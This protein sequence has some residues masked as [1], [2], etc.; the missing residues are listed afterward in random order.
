[1]SALKRNHISS[2][3]EGRYFNVTALL[4][5]LHEWHQGQAIT[6]KRAVWDGQVAHQVKAIKLHTRV[7]LLLDI[8]ILNSKVFLLLLIP[9]IQ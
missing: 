1:M 7:L 3:L 6:E 5:A 2:F 9:L 4:I 8:Y